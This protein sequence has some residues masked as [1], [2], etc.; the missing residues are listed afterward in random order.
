MCYHVVRTKKAVS[1]QKNGKSYGSTSNIYFERALFQSILL[2]GG[3]VMNCIFPSMYSLVV[4]VAGK[5]VKLDWL[6][7]LAG[8]FVLPQRFFNELFIF[9]FRVL[10]CCWENWDMMWIYIYNMH[11]CSIYFHECSCGQQKKYS[12]QT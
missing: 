7:F 2:V 11:P 12:Q 4:S 9:C 8:T 5:N 6:T 10:K 1:K 3:F